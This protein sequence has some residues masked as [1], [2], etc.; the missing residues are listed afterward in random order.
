MNLSMYGALYGAEEILSKKF[1][2]KKCHCKLLFYVIAHSC[3]SV[4]GS[5][6][7]NYLK[8]VI[9]MTLENELRYRGSKH[10]VI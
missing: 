1:F 2:A 8:C 5:H 6:H 7:I 9:I 3:E 4:V 10:V